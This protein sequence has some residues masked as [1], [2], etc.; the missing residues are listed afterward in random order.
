MLKLLFSDREFIWLKFDIKIMFL[1]G[2][3]VKIL[4]SDWLWYQPN[5]QSSVTYISDT[6]AQKIL[7]FWILKSSMWWVTV[8]SF[9]K[10]GD[11][12]VWWLLIW[13]GMT[14]LQSWRRGGAS[15]ISWPPIFHMGVR[16]VSL[17]PKI[18]YCINIILLHK[19]DIFNFLR[20]LE[21]NKFLITKYMAYRH[22][23]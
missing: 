23:I 3:E 8:P 13:R 20:P 7:K 21:L 12:E 22:H 4:R 16:H 15:W 14:H 1:G 9:I 6:S 5:C 17:T 2:I 19:Y 18:F 11:F 10:I